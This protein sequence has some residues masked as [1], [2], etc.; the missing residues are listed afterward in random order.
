MFLLFVRCYLVTGLTGGMGPGGGG[1]EGVLAMLE[2]PA[3]HPLLLSN[4]LCDK[5]SFQSYIKP[6]THE[7]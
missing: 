4:M 7:K 5:N 2:D 3:L 6:T 1:G